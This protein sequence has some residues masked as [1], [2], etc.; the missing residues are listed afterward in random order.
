MSSATDEVG[1]R[2]SRLFNPTTLSS[3]APSSTTT[4]TTTTTTIKEQE[5]EEEEEEKRIQYEWV[6]TPS[7]TSNRFVGAETTS[8]KKKKREKNTNY[9]SQHMTWFNPE[10]KTAE[11]RSWLQSN[12]KLNKNNIGKVVEGVDEDEDDC[13]PSTSSG[14]E[15]S[16]KRKRITFE[17]FLVVGLHPDRSDFTGRKRRK[18]FAKLIIINIINKIIQIIIIIIII[19][20]STMT[21]VIAEET[22]PKTCGYRNR[23]TPHRIEE[24]L[25]KRTRRTFCFHIHLLPLKKRET[26]TTTTKCSVT[27]NRWILNRSHIFVFRMAW[28]Q[29]WW[30]KRHRCPKF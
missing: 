12:R 21:L 10:A 8:S 3:Q 6:P 13:S 16:Q 4:T 20:T 27:R 24:R 29:N 25:E 11:K 1:G 14:N 7:P 15:K 23:N 2:W 26:T 17:K 22:R 30:R 18:S 28:N 9:V 19:I 5:E